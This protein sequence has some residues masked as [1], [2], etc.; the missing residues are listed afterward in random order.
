MLVEL[1]GVDA[2]LGV[3]VEGA[4]LADVEW[5]VGEYEVYAVIVYEAVVGVVSDGD[6]G[7][8]HC[9]VVN[10]VLNTAFCTAFCT[11]LHTAP[12]TVLSGV[13]GVF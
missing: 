13:N 2:V 4:L 3:G 5:W 10:C 11:V 7:G 9:T 1:V 6:V 8:V 12:C